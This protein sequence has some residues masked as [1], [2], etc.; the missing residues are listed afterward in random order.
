MRFIPELVHNLASAL[1][2]RAPLGRNLIISA[3]ML[4][5]PY[6]TIIFTLMALK[7][8]AQAKIIKKS[9]ILFWVLNITI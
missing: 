4:N 9:V 5:E 7:L 1:A 8:L 6:N 3:S 2:L